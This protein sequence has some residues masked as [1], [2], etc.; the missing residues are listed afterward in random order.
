VPSLTFMSITMPDTN[1]VLVPVGEY[2][3][4]VDEADWE[5]VRW[6]RWSPRR[7]RGGNVYAQT[8]VYGG[9]IGMHRFLVGCKDPRLVV[10][11]IDGVGLNCR[12]YNLREATYRQN[13]QNR[14]G[15]KGN[16]S[17]VIG[18]CWVELRRMYVVTVAGKTVGWFRDRDEAIQA[19]AAAALA[20][21][22]EFS[23]LTDKTIL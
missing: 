13:M 1:Y 3:A 17:G 19:R 6:R 4:A 23:R 5:M 2:F 10:D 9:T 8:G 18:V 11:H 22:G 20:E 7:E 21:W 14:S 12:R 16:V 15:R